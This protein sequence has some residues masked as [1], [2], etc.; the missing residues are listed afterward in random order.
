MVASELWPNTAWRS[1]TD[2]LFVVLCHPACAETGGA[3]RPRTEADLLT[4]QPV[5]RY[6]FRELHA[7]LIERQHGLDPAPVFPEPFQVTGELDLV[8]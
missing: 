4:E 3:S 5:M 7:Q 8:V 6:D 2:I 1:V